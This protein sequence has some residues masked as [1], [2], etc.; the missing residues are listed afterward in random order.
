MLVECFISHYIQAIVLYKL[1]YFNM[2]SLFESR[3]EKKRFKNQIVWSGKNCDQNGDRVS[4][5]DKKFHICSMGIK[6]LFVKYE[7]Y[8]TLS[9]NNIVIKQVFMVVKSDQYKDIFSQLGSANGK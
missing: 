3:I 9:M 7:R 8:G 6:R 5:Y 2:L 1:K 4:K